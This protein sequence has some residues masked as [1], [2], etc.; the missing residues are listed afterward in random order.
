[1]KVSFIV[2]LLF[3]LFFLPWKLTAELRLNTFVT[4]P[5]YHSANSGC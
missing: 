4:V 2:F 5:V 3:A 1:M